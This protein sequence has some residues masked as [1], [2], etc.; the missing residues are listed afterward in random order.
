M[1]AR[2]ACIEAVI[3]DFDGLILDTET[4]LFETWRETFAGQGW[5]L[6][7]DMWGGNVGGK[8]YG[9]FDPRAFIR[10]NVEDAAVRAELEARRRSAYLNRLAAQDCLPGVRAAIAHV[11][12]RGLCLAVASSSSR[13][14]VGGHLE[15]LG[16]L[17]DFAC[18]LCKDDVTEI[19]PDPALYLRALER[20]GAVA[21]HAVAIE[22]SP[23]GARAA[24]AAGMRCVVVPNSTTAHLDFSHADRRL[25]SLAAEP[26]GEVLNGIEEMMN[27][28]L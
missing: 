11:K 25:E 27:G 7:L 2:T 1:G 18:L 26:F 16:L 13:R 10:D 20:L 9:D 22:D 3:F 6:D 4:A 21:E 28:A 8:D 17:A 15:R 14:W 19:K 24:K 12:A 5:H 23:P